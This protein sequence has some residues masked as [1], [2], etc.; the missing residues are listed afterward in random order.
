MIRIRNLNKCFGDHVLFQD[1]NIDI[2]PGEFVV[3]MG[4]SGC[5]KTTLLN[6]IG[7][8]EKFDS[9]SLQSCGIDLVR[10]KNLR[11]YYG[12]KVGFLFQNFILI[13][14]KTVEYNLSLIGRKNR[15]QISEEEALKRVGL[16][17][18][19]QEKVYT[20]SGGE[21]QRIALARLMIKKCDLIL[22]DE[23]T[24]SLDEENAQRVVSILKDLN[25]MG[26]TIVAVSHNHHFQDVADRV[27]YL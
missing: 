26:K 11:K 4:A 10:R 27:V 8:L 19:M 24:G 18:K 23:P 6:M 13:E 15:S 9:G 2:M 16:E 3:F 14:D 12:E 20:L 21:Q 5:G 1:F 7:G 25:Q 17:H 22:A